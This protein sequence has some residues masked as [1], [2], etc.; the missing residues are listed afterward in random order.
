MEATTQRA[1]GLVLAPFV[2]QGEE[3]SMGDERKI[4]GEDCPE[5]ALFVLI[6]QQYDGYNAQLFFAGVARRYFA[7]QDL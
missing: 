5:T 2:L 1:R 6:V 7:L 4:V 3:K